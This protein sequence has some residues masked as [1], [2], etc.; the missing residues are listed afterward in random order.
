MAQRIERR[1]FLGA[2]AGALLGSPSAQADTAGQREVRLEFL[3]PKELEE[4]RAACATV[5]QPLGTIEW[6]GVHNVLGLDAVKAHAL[7]VRAAQKGGGVV[8]RPCSAVSVV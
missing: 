4:A 6:H 2:A 5:F 1:Q 3:H 8:S 7:C